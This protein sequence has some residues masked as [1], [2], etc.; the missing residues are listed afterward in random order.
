MPNACSG[1]HVTMR[2]EVRLRI[3]RYIRLSYRRMPHHFRLYKFKIAKLQYA[4]VCPTGIT[5]T[6]FARSARYYPRSRQSQDRS[7]LLAVSSVPIMRPL[8]R[9]DRRASLLLSWFGADR[10][11]EGLP[12]VHMLALQGPIFSPPPNLSFAIHANQADISGNLPRVE[13][14]E[15]VQS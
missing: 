3:Y 4:F 5:E 1:G 12:A 10:L 14:T 11:R 15:L 8:M 13:L 6:F 2:V 9:P 7:P